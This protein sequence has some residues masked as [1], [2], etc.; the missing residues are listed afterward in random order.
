MWKKLLKT[1]QQYPIK[2]KLKDVTGTKKMWLMMAEKSF[3]L[4][5]KCRNILNIG[6]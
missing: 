4:T 1:M 2:G 3:Y 6:M 5:C